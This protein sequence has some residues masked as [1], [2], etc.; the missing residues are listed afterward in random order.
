MRSLSTAIQ[1]ATILRALLWSLAGWLLFIA[2]NSPPSRAGG[3][4]RS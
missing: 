3:V 4:R 2:H 1:P